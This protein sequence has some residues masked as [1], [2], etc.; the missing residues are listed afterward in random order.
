MSFELGFEGY[1]GFVAKTRLIRH[2]Q[3]SL[4]AE[5]VFGNRMRIGGESAKKL[6]NLYFKEFLDG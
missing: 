5:L 2:Y 4:G 1:V 3:E 6:V